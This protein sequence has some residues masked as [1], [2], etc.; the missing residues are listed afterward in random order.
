MGQADY[1]RVLTEMR[2]SDGTL[3]PIPITLTINKADL[4]T[5]EEW[6]TLRD[7]H[8]YIIAVMRI[9]EVFLLGPHPR[10]CAWC[11]APTDPRHPLVSEMIS[12][13]DLCISGELKVLNPP[14]YYDFVELRRTPA[15]GARAVRARWARKKWSPSRRATPCTAS[16]R[17]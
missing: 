14:T 9:E 4:P 7:S 12:W 15:A 17:N 2:L 6:I 16:T 1:H 3:F 13:G 8:N 11:S 10:E 5:R